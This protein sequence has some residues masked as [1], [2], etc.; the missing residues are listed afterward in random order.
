MLA[1]TVSVVDDQDADRSP[2]SQRA[3]AG[4][5]TVAE[6]PREPSSSRRH[7]LRDKL[8]VRHCISS[9]CIRPG[10]MP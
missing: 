3:P 2:L 7:A 5:W 4:D 6:P 9:R 10:D 8:D 1:M